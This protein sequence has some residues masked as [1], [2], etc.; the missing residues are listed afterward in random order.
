MPGVAVLDLLGQVQLALQATSR[1][2]L[3]ARKLA[4]ALE[5]ERLV[6]SL[7]ATIYRG[8]LP[9]ELDRDT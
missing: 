1:R 2:A 7:G 3:E 6:E 8:V 9:A 4:V 5:A